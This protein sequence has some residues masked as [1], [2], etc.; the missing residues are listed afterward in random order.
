MTFILHRFKTDPSVKGATY[1]RVNEVD[2]VRFTTQSV[3][4]QT[5]H[6]IDIYMDPGYTDRP[7]YRQVA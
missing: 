2:I 4:K 3:V 5:I 7:T 6:W 1:S